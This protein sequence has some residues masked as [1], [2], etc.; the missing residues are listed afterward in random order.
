MAESGETRN[1][2]P[3][4][5]EA[6]Q[7][8]A[9]LDANGQVIMLGI[10]DC[11]LDDIGAKY[12]DQEVLERIVACV[13]FCQHLPTETLEALL[14]IQVGA[15]TVL[16]WLRQQQHGCRVDPDGPDVCWQCQ[17]VEPQH[18]E[19][20]LLGKAVE[21]LNPRPPKKGEST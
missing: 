13:K 7:S 18:G 16:Q 9:L 2:S 17:H 10:R 19:D 1:H 4:P 20:C 8:G 6:C 12:T 15:A 21:V 5:W 14:E 11:V 3:E